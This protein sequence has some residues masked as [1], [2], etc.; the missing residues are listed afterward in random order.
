MHKEDNGSGIWIV[1]KKKIWDIEAGFNFEETE[2]PFNTFRCKSLRRLFSAL[3][4]LCIISACNL[5]A[6]AESACTLDRAT[7]TTIES[8]PFLTNGYGTRWNFATNRL[9]FMQQGPDKYYRVY[10]MN[11]DGSGRLS[12]TDGFPGLSAKHHGAP[13]WHPSGRYLIFIA[14]KQEWSGSALFGNPDYEALPGFGRH[15]DMWLITAEGDQAWQLTHEANTVDEGILLPV[16]SPDGSRIAWAERLPGGKYAIK[17]AEFIE[18]PVPHLQNARTYQPG[19]PSYYEP[20]SFSSDGK[21]LIYTSDQDTHSFW[22]SQIYRLDLESGKGTRLTT[23]SDYNEHP[24]VINT[25]DG[26]RIV[27]MSTRG[28]DRYPWELFLGTDWYAMKLDGSGT[29]RLTYMNIN[30]KSNPQNAGHM[31]VA[32]TVA[33]SPSG[34][35]MLG[36]V[37]DS[38]T[39]QTGYSRVVH[40]TCSK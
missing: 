39:K 24:S 20:G 36:D 30:R 29:K 5:S 3:L 10:T 4:I 8:K 2:M 28:V 37:Q 12:L 27:Y 9:A 33:V 18:T 25:P 22:Q 26:D 31:Q 40:F 16:F 14:Q 34:D 6:M 7:G 17:I 38:L 23:K 1:H 13:Y 35:F 19:G 32:G 11:P 15:D 21:S